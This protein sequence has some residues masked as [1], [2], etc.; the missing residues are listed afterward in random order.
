MLS[1]VEACNPE[2]L[3]HARYKLR[4]GMSEAEESDI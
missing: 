1:E 2:H 4:R 3:D